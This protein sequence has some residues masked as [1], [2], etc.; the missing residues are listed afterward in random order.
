MVME[1]IQIGPTPYDENCAQ[2]GDD[3]YRKDAKKEMDVY[4]NQLNRTFIDAK[5]K[6]IAFKQRWFDHDF[7]AYGEV[8]I[9]WNTE[10]PV[11]DEYAY[12]IERNLPSD[13]DEEAKKE[14]TE[15]Y[16]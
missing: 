13:W 9:Y 16:V 14:L 4:I 10:N 8:C 5:S 2:V 1:Y 3:D 6:G 12:V 11:A 7:G 15:S